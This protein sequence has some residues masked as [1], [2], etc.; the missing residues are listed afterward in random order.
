MKGQI[1]CQEV[2]GRGGSWVVRR[3]GGGEASFTR[4]LWCRR[5]HGERQRLERQGRFHGVF[6]CATRNACMHTYSRHACIHAYIRES[7]TF[8]DFTF[9]LWGFGCRWLQCISVCERGRKSETECKRL[10]G[11]SQRARANREDKLGGASASALGLCLYMTRAC[12]RPFLD[13][14]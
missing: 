4:D 9:C 13:D 11:I 5:V 6:G 2:A 7:R 14:S 3:S 12:P 8:S 1:G 10:R